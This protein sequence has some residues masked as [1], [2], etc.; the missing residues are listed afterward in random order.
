M[1]NALSSRIAS[2]GYMY[3]FGNGVLSSLCSTTIRKGV[4]ELLEKA[5]ENM[6][7]IRSD[8]TGV[9]HYDSKKDIISLPYSSS[10]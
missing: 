9:A 3:R 10:E 2:R 4:E 6:V 5:R 8:S 7:E 1:M